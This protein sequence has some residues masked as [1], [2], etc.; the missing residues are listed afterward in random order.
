MTERKKAVWYF[1]I[2]SP[3]AYLQLMQ[4]ETIRDRLEVT[5]VPVVLGGILSYW[6]QKGPAEI[7]TKRLHTYRMSQWRAQ[8]LGVTFRFPPTHPFNPIAALRLIVALDSSWAAIAAMFKAAFAEGRD[9]ADPLEIERL[10]QTL[11]VD[12]P[13]TRIAKPDIKD[14][15]RA[16]TDR[17]IADGAF[18]VPTFVVDGEMFWGEDALRLLNGYL[19]DPGLFTRGEM[20]RL[21]TIPVGIA[22]KPAAG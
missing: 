18:G 21:A 19:D 6:G 7:E 8:E 15:L 17:A 11:G 9:L 1:D 14:R 5:P 16:N 4:M 22:R 10:G 3:F 13:A 12:D 2:V 20:A